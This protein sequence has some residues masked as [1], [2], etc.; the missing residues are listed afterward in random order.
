M[1]SSHSISLMP[2]IPYRDLNT[3]IEW[4]SRA[5]NFSTK[6]VVKLPQG[7]V[8]F[9]Q[10][11]SR[12][13]SVLIFPIA[14]S[15]VE[16]FFKHPDEIGGAQTQSCYLIVEDIEK[17]HARAVAAGATIVATLRDYDHGGREYSC[18][19]LDGHIW[20]FG[21]SDPV[22]EAGSKKGFWNSSGRKGNARG[23]AV[24]AVCGAALAVALVLYLHRPLPP[25][26]DTPR[27]LQSQAPTKPPS[28]STAIEPASTRAADVADRELERLRSAVAASERE[29]VELERRLAEKSREMDAARIA[30]DGAKSSA[31]AER[32]NTEVVEANLRANLARLGDEL[33]QTIESQKK[34]QSQVEEAQARSAETGRAL[35]NIR[36]EL[37]EERAARAQIESSARETSRLLEE[38]RKA[39]AAA[40]ARAAQ[41]MA[42]LVRAQQSRATPASAAT[43]R[44]SIPATRDKASGPPASPPMPA[45]VP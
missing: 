24:F 36:T 18:R 40:E 22:R 14:H 28:A 3:A 29:R 12:D 34:S 11:G 6:H 13:A 27:V 42:D 23:T 43:S 30:A 25:Q 33:T 7:G 9:A 21:T 10:L 1:S 8:A 32:Q 20:T 38:E 35:S 44:K 2:A 4:L 16:G 41:T 26:P 39:K 31:L 15:E 37:Q 17:H 45:F 5:F 19:D